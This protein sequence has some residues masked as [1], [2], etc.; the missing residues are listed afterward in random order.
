MFKISSNSGFWLEFENGLTLSVQ[1]GYGN[2]CDNY[3]RKDLFL[4][5]DFMSCKDAE[6]AVIDKHDNFVTP[7]FIDCNSDS[8]KGRLSVDEVAEVI[9]KVKEWKEER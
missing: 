6:I 8:V 4:S 1:F 5:K 2:Y 9:I 3:N 7:L